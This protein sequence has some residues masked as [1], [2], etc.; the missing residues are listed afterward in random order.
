MRKKVKNLRRPYRDPSCGC[1]SYKE[2]WIKA[3]G[4]SFPEKCSRYRCTRDAEVGAHV[5]NC[6]KTSSIRHLIVPLCKPCNNPSN[7]ECFEI[8][9]DAKTPSAN[10]LTRCN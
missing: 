4:Q 5:I 9:S 8:V 1:T 3:T 6:S 7:T 2:H 10:K